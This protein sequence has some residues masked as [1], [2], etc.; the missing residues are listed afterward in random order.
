[1][2]FAREGWPFLLSACLI[3]GAAIVGSWIGLNAI[4]GAIA[5]CVGFGFVALFLWFFRDPR[6]KPPRVE[7][8]VVSP[9]DGRIIEANRQ[10]NGR[11][12][13]AIFLSLFNVHVNRA[14]VSGRI[15]S[16][17]RRHGSYLPAFAARAA[18]RNARVD[19]V[20]ETEF[21]GV[22]WRQVSGMLARR[23]ACRLQRGDDVIQGERFGLIY[24]GSRM[25]VFLPASSDLTVR[26]G[27]QVRA[28]ETI[29]ARF[30]NTMER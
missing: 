9:A 21:G 30:Q 19:V 12:H 18:E 14:P 25:D 23:I 4:S 6:R 3:A 13:V 20:C 24:F 10:P 15:V 8:V 26:I 16:V 28:G 17:I 11:Q 1:M 22:R 2:R 27:D 29:I 7:A 5:G